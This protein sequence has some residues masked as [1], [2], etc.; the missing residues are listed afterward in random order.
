VARLPA[1]LRAALPTTL[2]SKKRIY[3]KDLPSELTDVVWGSF[4]DAL[5]PLRAAGKMGSVL[6]QYP[7][8]F[9]PSA[10]SRAVLRDARERAGSFTAAVEFRNAAWMDGSTR[11]R[12]LGLLAEL[13]M[14]FV[15]VD[16]PQGTRSSMPPVVGVT[17]PRLAVIRFHGRRTETWEAPGVGVEER[18]RYLYDRGELE[19]W[20]PR[21]E[22]AAAQAR[23]VHVVMNNCYGN[24]G[25]A[26]ASELAAMVSRTYAAG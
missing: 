9:G 11:D 26:N 21:I 24:Y 7:R 13:E 3:A 6:L 10:A 1:D 16:A 17:D 5:A 18:F 12:T 25:T 23:D 15:M 2:A 22:Q 4:L 20:V 8:W 19:E 14:P